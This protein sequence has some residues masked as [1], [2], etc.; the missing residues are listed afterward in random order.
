MR[1]LHQDEPLRIGG[2]RLVGVLGEGAIAQVFVGATAEGK[3]VAV[4]TVRAAAAREPGFRARFAREVS[5]AS[6]MESRYAVPVVD[7]DTAGPTPW[8]ATA[9]LP[10][11]SLAEAVETHGRLPGRTV[12][13]LAAGIADALAAL[14]EV[15]LTHGRL[16]P[17]HIA[18]APDGPRI[19]DLGVARSPDGPTVTDRGVV[20]G[21]VLPSPGFRSPEQLDGRT[22]EA[23]SDVFSLGSLL[24]FAATGN[25]PFGADDEAGTGERV[26]RGDPNLTELPDWLRELV[27]ACVAKDP[28]DRPTAAQ[29][30]T[31][32]A[33]EED[34]LGWL[35]STL[36]A[37]VAQRAAAVWGLTADG[38]PRLGTDVL[39]A[40]D[41]PTEA[42]AEVEA[43]AARPVV[44]GR[45]SGNRL[46][47][48]L[49]TGLA[50]AA[51]RMSG[52]ASTWDAFAPRRKASEDGLREMGTRHESAGAGASSGTGAA[53][54]SGS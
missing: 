38:T 30:R 23:P 25:P 53:A 13:A 27:A 49:M 48:D 10:G 9:Y 1:A 6:R 24:A 14:H 42:D 52:T 41:L 19:V 47:D 17:H 7:A 29:I 11:P 40:D 36:S 33:T 32:T 3:P 16:A 26:L 5:A 35:P 37:E 39:P 12:R 46:V 28:A 50:G 34:G 43:G 45:S 21:T 20:V 44:A 2:I 18:F 51:L 8:L 22:A 15:G 4:K 31:A 54:G